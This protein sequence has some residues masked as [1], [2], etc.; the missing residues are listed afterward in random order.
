MN[1]Y[2]IFSEL[3]KFLFSAKKPSFDVCE[4]QKSK[5]CIGI[6]LL[7]NKGVIKSGMND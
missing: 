7:N 1:Y 4:A 5:G 6:I 2:C 3:T